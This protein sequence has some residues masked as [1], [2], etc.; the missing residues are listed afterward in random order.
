VRYCPACVE[1]ARQARG[2]YRA[3]RTPRYYGRLT[4]ADF[5]TFYATWQPRAVRYMTAILGNRADA[6]DVVADVL[7]YTFTRLDTLPS[8]SPGQIMRWAKYGGWRVRT[9]A[10]RRHVASVGGLAE[11]ED[12]DA[13]HGLDVEVEGLVA[14]AER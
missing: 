3:L 12:Y 1:A 4:V 10:W 9:T 13:H 2:A 11:L 7:L 5:E 8:L 6:E 14:P